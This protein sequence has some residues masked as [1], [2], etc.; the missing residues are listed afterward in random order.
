VLS[1]RVA[2]G[3]ALLVTEWG[4]NA[5]GLE[6]GGPIRFMLPGDYAMRSVKWVTRIEGVTSPFAG[7][8]VDR[9]RYLGDDRHDEGSPVSTIEVRSV[10]VTP[11]EGETVRAG[12]LTVSGSAWS[13]TGPVVEVSVSTD[14][15]ATWLGADIEPGRHPLAASGWRCEVELA[16][17]PYTVMA[18]A[19]DVTGDTQPIEPP[20][21][22][23]GYA[24]NMAHRVSFEVAQP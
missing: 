3:S 13:G 21:N 11:R 12:R 22:A 14:Q 18:R 24:N 1:D 5:L 2:D 19:T 23:R 4:G 8:F 7:H 10:I 16:P 9:Y 17:G 20:W 15:G 6:H